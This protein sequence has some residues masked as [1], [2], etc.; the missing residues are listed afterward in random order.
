MD[1]E[2]KNA[3]LFKTTQKKPH[4]NLTQHVGPGSLK[5]YNTNERNQRSRSLQRPTILIDWQTSYTKPTSILSK[6]IYEF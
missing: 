3:V 2:I 4:L 5:T 6:S 1:I